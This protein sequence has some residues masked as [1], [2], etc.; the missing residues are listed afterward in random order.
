MRSAASIIDRA[1]LI[2]PGPVK[3]AALVALELA[4]T[5]RVVATLVIVEVLVR[6]MP[7]PRLGRLLGC[8]VD[9][10][11]TKP[12]TPMTPMTPKNLPIH[13]GELTRHVRRPRLRRQTLWQRVTMGKYQQKRR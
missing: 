13:A 6:A 5:I 10:T 8:H 12:M 2:A 11:P 3:T 4:T 9:L 1:K 7:L